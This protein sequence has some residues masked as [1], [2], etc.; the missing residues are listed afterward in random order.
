MDTVSTRRTGHPFYMYDA[1]QAQPEA[2]PRVCARADATAGDWARRI[3]SCARIYISGI[4]TSHH[5]AQVG[6][7]L[8]RAYGG[9]IPTSAVH[10]F[11]FALYGPALGPHDCVICVS[12]RGTKRYSADALARAR[13]AGCLTVLITGEGGGTGGAEA[14]I[15]FYT[16]PQEKSSAHTVSYTGATAVLTTLSE[17][18]G[19]YR[20]KVDPFSPAFLSEDIPTA[21]RAALR[22][23]ETVA[24]LAR[25]HLHRRRIWLVGGGPSSI[26]AQE[27]ALKIKETSYLQAEGMPI[28]TMLHGPFQCTEP[29]DLFVLVAPAGA[30]QPR[31]VEF[32]R[33]LKEIGASFLVVS[34]GTPETLR[35]KVGAWITV[36]AVP[37]PFTALVCLVP[38]QLFTYHLAL[39]RGTNPDG[40]RLEVSRFARI[41][42]LVPL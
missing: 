41:R 20:A 24:T 42:D 33:A 13:T 31:V 39:Q 22:T 3:A 14:D 16:V 40:F 37:E 25:G 26:I 30:A 6:A 32:G 15:V 1:I 12:H 18:V 17:R 11:D 7:H 8:F 9:G 27:V 5:A 36:P 2:F 10:S 19:Q 23:E 4:G 35:E 29:D 21:L 28:E 34:D 38:L